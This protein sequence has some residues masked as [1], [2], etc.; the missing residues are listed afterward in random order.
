MKSLWF[1]KLVFRLSGLF[2]PL[3]LSSFLSVLSITV[4]VATLLVSMALVDSYEKSF[5][6]SI[7]SVFSHAL[8]FPSMETSR[9]MK[10][11]KEDIKAVYDQSFFVV[12]ESFKKEGLLAHKG[13]V[14]GVLLEGVDQ[15]SIGKVIDLKSKL[16]EGEYIIDGLEVLKT[17]RVLL[18]KSLYNNFGLSIGDTFSV[19]IPLP[20]LREQTG[21]SRKVLTYKVGG[22]VD[23]GSHSYNKRFIIMDQAHANIAGAKPKGYFSEVR[24]RFLDENEAV[25]FK[26]KFSSAYPERYWVQ[27]WKEKSGGLLEAIKIERL[28]IFF[29]VLILVV[30]AAFN[31]STNLYLNLAKRLKELSVLQT[32]GM[33]KRDISKFMICNGLLLASFGVLFGWLLAESVIF[34]C[35]WILRAGLFVP[36]EVYKLTSISIEL[37]FFQFLVVSLSTFLICFLASLA[38]AKSVYGFSIVKGLRY[39]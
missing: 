28:V 10:K 21:F 18:G 37:S 15:E 30:V 9:S 13:K 32:I 16:I 5:K 20:S 27:T 25:D 23:L 12:S 1:Y 39:E 2:K 19:V 38:P 22:V 35:N 4:G 36:P 17:P 3:N 14:S 6:E 24:M 8:I 31:V 11:I 29:L 26:R 33:S 7:H 34:V